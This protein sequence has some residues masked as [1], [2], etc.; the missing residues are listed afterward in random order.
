M[1]IM[2]TRAHGA[3]SRRDR[4]LMVERFFLFNLHS[5]WLVSRCVC[6]CVHQRY[7]FFFR[8]VLRIITGW[9]CLI[10]SNGKTII[11]FA[12]SVCLHTC[13]PENWP[14]IDKHTPRTFS[15]CSFVW[16]FILEN[17]HVRLV[18][19]YHSCTLS[20]SSSSSTTIL[21]S[22]RRGCIPLKNVMLMHG[23][24][25]DDEVLFFVVRKECE[26]QCGFNRTKL[27]CIFVICLPASIA[28]FSH[29]LLF[30]RVYF[31]VY[32]GQIA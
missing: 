19:L 10:G 31:C 4:L 17:V 1:K 27:I 29:S 32:L 23:P 24:I 7:M 2:N 11:S 9:F 30:H 18:L 12:F 26:R 22:L 5:F 6:V 3:S 15:W 28:T 25:S 20:S 21:L 16:L 8:F 14:K 13:V